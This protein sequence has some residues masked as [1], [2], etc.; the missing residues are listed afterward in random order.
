MAALLPGQ[1]FARDEGKRVTDSLGRAVVVPPK[2]D[3]IACLYAFTAHVVAMLGRADD[4]VAVSN[5]PQRDI[6]LTT[7]Y[8]SIKK[9]LVPKFQ[10]GI[11]VEEL[12]KA[13]PDI[14]F[15]PAETGRNDGEVAKLDACGL[16]WLAVDFHTIEEQQ[17]VVAMI[18]AAIGKPEKAG[19]YNI[20]YRSCIARALDAVSGIPSMKKTG[21]YHATN[22]ATRTSQPDSLSADWMRAAGIINVAAQNPGGLLDGSNQVSIEQILLWNPDVIL[23]NEPGV[24]A[25]IKESPQWSAVAAVQNDRVYQ[26]PIGISRWGHPGSLETPLAVLWTVKTVYPDRFREVDMRYELGYFYKTFFDWE[27]S[28][29]MVE[30]ILSGKGMRLTKDKKKKQ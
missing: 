20:Y 13:K 21:V 18:G 15:V 4:I 22:E 19:A 10:G 9:A 6:L 17:Q 3:R 2:V 1:A 26:M 14:V 8:P 11:N 23:A 28:E 24:A 25:L 30:R 29:D 27:L 12:V 16:P 5:G 7:M